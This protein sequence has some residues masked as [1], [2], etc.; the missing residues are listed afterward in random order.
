MTLP[1]YN[2]PPLTPHKP[3]DLL[4]RVRNTPPMTDEELAGQTPT[5]PQM[6]DW[7]KRDKNT[8]TESRVMYVMIALVVAAWVAYVVMT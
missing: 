6:E 1:H 2:M 4:N 5:T 7:N 8:P 3:N